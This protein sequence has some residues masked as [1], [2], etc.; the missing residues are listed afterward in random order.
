MKKS[1]FLLFL[2]ILL[3]YSCGVNKK[4][5]FDNISYYKLEKNEKRI[6]IVKL[7]SIGCLGLKK[8]D[9][10]RILKVEYNKEK[11]EIIRY[12]NPVQTN[13]LLRR[14][15]SS[16][17]KLLQI[18]TFFVP[19][20]EEKI[21][22]NLYFV[23]E[24][25]VFCIYSGYHDDNQDYVTDSS[26]V[27]SDSKGKIKKVYKLFGS[28]LSATYN[29]KYI[30]SDLSADIM[31][32][33]YEPFCFKDNKL[34]VFFS[35]NGSV[36]GE[37]QQE[38]ISLAGYIDLKTEKFHSLE[39]YYPDINFGYDYY[40]YMIK[41]FF[42][43]FSHDGDLLFSFRYTPTMLKC[44]YKTGVVETIKVNGSVVDTVFPS[45]TINDV[46]T[47]IFPMPYPDNWTI[48]YDKFRH[49]YYRT[50]LLP[51]V[52]YDNVSILTVLDT[53]F[54]IIAEGYTKFVIGIYA[55]KDKLLIGNKFYDISFSDG[56]NLNLISE[57]NKKRKENLK[58]NKPLSFYLKKN[59]NIKVKDNT[60]TFLWKD[61]MCGGISD[62]VIDFYIKNNK[63]LSDNNK[64]LVVITQNKDFIQ[65]LKKQ[66]VH[67]IV[68]DSLNEIDKYKNAPKKDIMPRVIVYNKN[69]I[70]VDS[71]FEITSEK[72]A[73]NYQIFVG[74]KENFKYDYNFIKQNDF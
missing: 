54:N 29:S 20:I 55:L 3:L 64:Y 22:T 70:V 51:P 59:H 38:N 73:Y 33:L 52:D 62:M 37:M 32:N 74:N 56:T 26:F 28:A 4:G 30:Q 9:K 18:D 2:F 53:N 57:I 24:D 6:S 66:N 67:D 15:F 19:I 12:T 10:L 48:N 41:D 50:T 5:N 46:P 13:I 23:N 17:G 40:H 47:V 1:G 39:V 16:E 69:K 21:P 42:V 61:G 14:R 34:F 43:T 7:D 71:L 68:I 60:I 27:L 31:C 72:D 35:P 65:Y 8:Y 11:S 25:S 58:I 63:Y 49:V 45:K 36:L 44:N